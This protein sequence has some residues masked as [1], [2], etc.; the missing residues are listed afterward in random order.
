MNGQVIQVYG[1]RWIILGVFALVQTGIQILW[2]SFL[3]ITGDAAA[4]YGVTP[5]AIGFLSML[6]M[7][8]YI[9]ISL[10][11]SWVI[12]NHGVKKG[13]GFGVI[14]MAIFGLLRGILGD[15]YLAVMI[16]TVMLSVAQPFIINSITTV[17][18][19]WFPVGERAT[20]T[21]LAMLAQFI[22]IMG[23]MIVTPLLSAEI[24]IQSTLI[25]YGVFSA[26][27]CV[28]FFLIYRENPPTPPA[29]VVEEKEEELPKM[30]EGLKIVFKNR[31]AILVLIVFCVGM[32]T[33]NAVTTWIEQILAPR[34]FDSVDAGSIGGLMMAGAIIGCIILP[35]LSDK[36]RKR[37]IFVM[38]GLIVVVAGLLGL[39]YLQTLV[40][41]LITGGLI[42]F[43]LLGMSPIIME[44]AADV[45]KPATEATAQ[46]VLWMFGQG[47]SVICIFLMDAF[48]TETGAMTPF[49]LA[50]VALG[51]V[52]L[53][54]TTNINESSLLGEK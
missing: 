52:S 42:G 46:G 10:P 27:I 11:S 33:F 28:L 24:G 26:I 54:L 22:G 44:A 19:R 32:S 23:G 8:L 36:T 53:V 16:C 2:A 7:I 3:P 43:F 31:N 35:I 37:K 15:S 4:Y 17:T 40:P 20:A 21:G 45:C 14:V 1:Y 48:R 12:S 34:G 39:T 13:V 49:M 18:A 50:F 30:R 41:L 38:L 29:L 9:F 6:F 47:T 5:L 25:S 51:V